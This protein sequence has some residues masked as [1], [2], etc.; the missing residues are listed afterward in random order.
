MIRLKSIT[1]EAY[2][3]NCSKPVMLSLNITTKEFTSDQLP[4]G[5]EWCTSHLAH[6]RKYLEKF[7]PAEEIPTE[8]IIM[9]Y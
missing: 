5:Y 1:C 2:V 7:D 3:E 6:A 9:W 4:A 8:E